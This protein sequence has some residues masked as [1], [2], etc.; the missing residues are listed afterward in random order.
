[1]PVQLNKVVRRQLVS[2]DRKGRPLIVTLSPGDIISFRPKGAKRTV[3]VYIGHCFT[4]AQIATIDKE[5]SKAMA[6]YNT[7]RK[8]GERY[9]RKPRKP[10]LFYDK[11]YFDALR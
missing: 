4:L 7:R 5:Y 9:L 3:S 6:D 1:M 10:T 11:I 2:S 8:A